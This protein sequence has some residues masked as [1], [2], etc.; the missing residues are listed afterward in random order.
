MKN[1]NAKI[2]IIIRAP[3]QVLLERKND[4][5]FTIFFLYNNININYII[6]FDDSKISNNLFK[7]NTYVCVI[8]DLH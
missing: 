2:T 1:I 7:I 8:V 4:S 5:F 3:R 6:N